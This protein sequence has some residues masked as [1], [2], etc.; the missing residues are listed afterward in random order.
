MLLLLVAVTVTRLMTAVIVVL[1]VEG[2]SVE[3]RPVVPGPG[4]QA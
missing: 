2:E 4:V 3:E 1:S